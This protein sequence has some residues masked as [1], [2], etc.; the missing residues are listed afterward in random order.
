MPSAAQ[1]NSQW[2]P[3]IWGWAD[4]Q[5]SH[6]ENCLEEAAAWGGREG[7]TAWRERIR[8]ERFLG[9]NCQIGETETERGKRRD[10]ES[11]GCFGFLA[12]PYNTCTI[13]AEQVDPRH[14]INT[15]EV[16]HTQIDMADLPLLYLLVIPLLLA[17]PLLCW[18][19]AADAQRARH[20]PQAV[21]PRHTRPNA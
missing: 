2:A 10:R 1:P 18:N 8:R 11:C 19:R 7:L 16:K 21:G 17:I 20:T 9:R 14:G 4:D 13:V 3:G 5:K 15:R 12:A 6:I